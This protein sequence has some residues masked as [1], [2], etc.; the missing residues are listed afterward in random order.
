MAK[1]IRALELIAL[2]N[3]LVLIMSIIVMVLLQLIDLWLI[4]EERCADHEF[5]KTNF[6]F[7]CIVVCGLIYSECFGHLKVSLANTSQ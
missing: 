2:S 4:R 6:T 7:T 1:P 3:D 5:N